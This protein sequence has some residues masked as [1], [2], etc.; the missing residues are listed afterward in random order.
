M[1]HYFFFSLGKLIQPPLVAND[2]DWVSRYWCNKK[3]DTLNL[4]DMPRVQR[5][6]LIS[7]TN[8]FTDF[9]ID[10]G[11]TSVWYHVVKVCAVIS[12]LNFL[13]KLFFFPLKINFKFAEVST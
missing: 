3:N 5:Y 10:F 12:Y 11:G 9:H 13:L 2:L 8:A 6:C 1:F 7:P 4:K